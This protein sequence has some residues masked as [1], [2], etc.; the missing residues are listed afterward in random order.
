MG[1]QCAHPCISMPS[2]IIK[3]LQKIQACLSTQA[4]TL[5]GYAPQPKK[6]GSEAQCPLPPD[7]SPHLSNANIKHVQHI[8][9]SILYY[10]CAVDLTVLMPLSTI[11]SKQAKG[12]QQTM[13]KSKQLLDYLATHPDAMVCFHASDMI[14]NFHSDTLYLSKANAHSRACGHFFHGLVR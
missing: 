13:A 8:I 2:Y 10:A 4:S 11:A 3:Q 9:G 6:F 7:T 1:L 12:T 5:S 14:L